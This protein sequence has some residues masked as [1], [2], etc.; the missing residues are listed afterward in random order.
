MKQNQK[1]NQA[2]TN[3]TTANYDQDFGILVEAG[4]IA[5]K[6]GDEDS[7]VKLFNAAQVLRPQHN[8]P[9]IGFG[10]IALNKLE[11][12]RAI[13]IF[14]GVVNNEATNYLA[15]TFLG[16][17]LMIEKT[18]LQRGYQLVQEVL[19]QCKDESVLQFARETLRWK[20][21][22]FEKATAGRA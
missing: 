18:D 17:C 14:Q 16:L 3:T 19:N 21:Q 5:V 2:N 9:R 22:Y 10:Y 6:Q 12:P 13:E 7:A 8:A 20:A 4:F 1:P 15:R 11:I